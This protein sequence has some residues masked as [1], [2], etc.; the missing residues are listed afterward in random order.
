[1][2]DGVF[3]A[4]RF[5]VGAL[6]GMPRVD[7]RGVVI[8]ISLGMFPECCGFSSLCEIFGSDEKANRYSTRESINLP[9]AESST[10]I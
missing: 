2:L 5:G 9:R 6:N 10:L 1:M 3:I 8:G 4:F 7:S